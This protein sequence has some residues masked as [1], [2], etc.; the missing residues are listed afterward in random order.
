[1]VESEFDDGPQSDF[2]DD[3]TDRLPP[4]ISSYSTSIN[5]RL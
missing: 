4:G 5:Y 1:M 2:N 3:I